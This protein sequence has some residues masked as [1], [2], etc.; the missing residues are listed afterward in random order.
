MLGNMASSGGSRQQSLPARAE[1][2]LKITPFDKREYRRMIEAREAAIRNV[3]HRVGS[4][5]GLRTALDAGAGV[6]FYSQT[7]AE[8]G[9]QVCGFDGREENVAEARRRY[10]QIPFAQG[11]LQERSI[12]ALGKFDLVLC[13][14]LLYHLENP[15]QAIRNLHGLTDK[16]LLLE[17]M[18]IPDDKP[19]ML[20][21]EE[22]REDDQSLTD[23]AFYPSESGLIKMLYRA[24]FKYVY[25]LASLPDHH[26]FRD[27]A[28]HRRRRTVLFAAHIPLDTAGFRLC[29][30]KCEEKDPW[31]RIAAPARGLPRRVGR[32]LGQPH[33]QKYFSIANR[34][35]R[36]FPRMPIPW[37]LSFGAWWLGED[38]EIDHKLVHEGFEGQEL[39]FVQR[40]LRPGMTVLD[41]GAHHGLYTLLCSKSV[42]SKGR[43]IAFEAS[44]RECRRLGKHVRIN[45][46]SNVRIEPCAAGSEHGSADFYVVDGPTDWGNSL[47]EPVVAEATYK[48]RVE[49]RAVDDVLQGLGISRVDFM[50]IDVEGA[51][52]EVLKGAMQLL[53]GVARPAI[54]VE[55]QELRTHP[56]G[57]RSRAIV[58]FLASLD[59]RWFSLAADGSLHVMSTDLESYDANL[60]A[61]PA[62]RVREFRALVERKHNLFG[63]ESP[64]RWSN[65]SRR[66]GKEI[67]QSMVRVRRS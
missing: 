16:C 18:C 36:S 48:I 33:R 37:R 4:T 38:G 31:S 10:P 2:I 17:S 63:A 67:L 29:T 45:S 34:I 19:S 49:V 51:E 61:F 8:C 3:L 64:A 9:L 57:Y 22:P 47:R 66:R 32:F 41:I 58:H 7:L 55:V 65:C 53:R 39:R 50:K 54:L 35:R 60:V 1:I 20:L 23:V 43:V 62:E 15:L 26:D 24:G 12:L 13:F 44:P 30:E 40:L 59:Y 6:G 11:D 28:E 25:R 14:G 5:L 27:T 42:G 46:C 56:W 52:L 21:R